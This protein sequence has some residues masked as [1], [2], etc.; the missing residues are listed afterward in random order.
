[1]DVLV[2][3]FCLKTNQLRYSG[4]EGEKGKTARKG[5]GSGREKGKKGGYAIG[6]VG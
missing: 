4:R 1:M 5:E 2:T 6:T 3:P